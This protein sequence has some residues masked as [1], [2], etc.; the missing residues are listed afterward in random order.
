MRGITCVCHQWHAASHVWHHMRV[1]PAACGITCVCHQRHAASHAWHRHQLHA[2]P[3]SHQLPRGASLR[4]TRLASQ[5]ATSGGG[6][7][8]EEERRDSV[9]LA[10]AGWFFAGPALLTSFG[11]LVPLAFE[12]KAGGRLRRGTHARSLFN[13][14]ILERGGLEARLERLGL[15]HGDFVRAPFFWNADVL[16]LCTT[17]RIQRDYATLSTATSES[18]SGEMHLH[19]GA[20]RVA[21][22]ACV[23]VWA[24]GGSRLEAA[25]GRLQV[26]SR[27]RKAEGGMFEP[28]G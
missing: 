1:P 27:R 12:G 13:A 22:R 15:E 18:A 9:V 25:G 21:A 26:G 10:L 8:E 4:C 7:P 23:V 14:L 17:A 20:L 5:L 3:V 19:G 6:S 24:G 16:S 11:L 2:A 28:G